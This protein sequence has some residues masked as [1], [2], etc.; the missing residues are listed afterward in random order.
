MRFGVQARRL[1]AALGLMAWAACGQDKGRPPA[2]AAPTTATPPTHAE[3]PPTPEPPAFAEGT[4]SLR[5][6]RSAGVWLAPGENGKRIGTVAQDTRVGWTQT[7]RDKG[8]KQAWVEITPRGWVC[9]E[10]LEP[11]TRAPSG[12]E[13]PRLERG[14]VVPG[15][16]GKVVEEGAMVYA[17]PEPPKPD[18]RKKPDGPV[19][20]PGELDE[21]AP[22][23]K[24]ELVPVRPLLGSVNVRQYG[25]I[26]VN[27]KAYWKI[28]RGNE[29][30]LAKSIRVHRASTWGGMR[31][32][33]DTGLSLPIAFVWPKQRG[34]TKAW[35]RRNAKGQGALRQVDQRT[36]FPVLEAY[37]ENGKV[38]SY[39]VGDGEW[40]L[41]DVVRIAEAA[42]PP[43]HVGPHERWFDID[44]DAQ[45]LVA[46][47]GKTPVYVTMVSTGKQATASPPGIWRIWK[48]VSETDMG[49]LSGEDPYSVATVPW[50]QF[51]DPNK[52]YALHAA[53]WHDSFGV[54]KSLGCIN[55]S[56]T[57]ARWLY[58]WSEPILPPGW[59]MAAGVVEAPGSIVRVRS[60]AATTL[61]Y[62]GYAKKVQ[63]EREGRAA[64]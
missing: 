14:E 56:P 10:Y 33:D 42:E 47:E 64:P 28:S 4:R 54:P 22:V 48:K 36:P 30:V 40:L 20:S 27:G 5:L 61:E 38:K 25:E 24:K 35:V 32:G 11:S 43:P 18:K 53:Y 44:L 1:L 45:I 3:P 21:P 8:C 60:K 41:A 7:V 6:I 37:E 50:T 55:L 19:S 17:L 16:Y 2:D 63:E 57:D 58:F 46:Y 59:T 23:V 52:G 49:G 39:R 9:G 26:T 13:L 29:Y 15:D 12:V 34:V 31:L 51:Y 62:R